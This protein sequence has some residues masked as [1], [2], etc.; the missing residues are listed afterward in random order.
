MPA[1]PSVRV[2]EPIR[3]EALTVFPLFS[4][5]QSAIAYLVSEEALSAGSLTVE[6]VSESGSVPTLLVDNR[7]ESPVLFLEGAE[8]RGAKQNRVL[9]TSLL[10]APQ[11]KTPIPVSCVEQGRWRHLSKHFVSGSHS[12]S[13]LRHI[14]KKT[15]TRS[16]QAGHGH[17]SNQGEVWQEVSRQMGSLGS[18]SPTGAMADTYEAFQNRLTE[19][20]SKLPYAEGAT[21]L[22]V[23]VGDK[24]VSVDLFDK[25]ATCQKVWAR[26]LEGV[27]LDALESG[28]IAT[29]ASTDQVQTMLAGLQAAPWQQAPAIGLGEEFRADLDGDRHATALVCQDTVVHGS[30]VAAG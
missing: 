17:S 29:T 16:A 30:L 6:E 26:L 7:A 1:F 23:A 15:V 25:P 2:A 22:A 27:I 5:T 13:K 10:V 24:V 18:H 8:L 12:S 21:G 3:H 20:R 4:E 9:N 11:S 19:Y 14:L 28:S